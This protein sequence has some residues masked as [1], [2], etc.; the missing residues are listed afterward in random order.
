MEALAGVTPRIN[1][2]I[3]LDFNGKQQEAYLEYL[4]Q[5]YYCMRSMSEIL[6][7]YDTQST[8]GRLRP[9]QVAKV[10][11]I[12]QQCVD[13]A[14][15]IA[16]KQPAV[17]SSTLQVPSITTSP[18]ETSPPTVPVRQNRSRTSSLKRNKPFLEAEQ[19][20]DRLMRTHQVKLQ[21]LMRSQLPQ[22][23]LKSQITQLN[24]A[25]AREQH[26]NYRIAKQKYNEMVERER[27]HLEP[28][29]PAKSEAVPSRS[30]LMAVL[31]Q[32]KDSFKNTITSFARGL[33]D[34]GEHPKASRLSQEPPLDSELLKLTRGVIE[35]EPLA[36][37]IANSFQDPSHPFGKNL[38][39]FILMW[40][41]ESGEDWIS[42]SEM[43][44]S[45][46]DYIDI[47]FIMILTF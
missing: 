8:T 33:S 36:D 42:F 12:F 29:E 39:E 22:D 40:K 21:K 47:L 24:L 25:L 15:A 26:E 10:F 3:S 14:K 7:T 1:H 13:R 28:S 27:Q 16:V 6:T 34:R 20:N 35:R 4:G 9:E 18:A 11:G 32:K 23:Q 37:H 5:Y 38:I 46:Q 41:L 31:S 44:H 2:A 17:V 30:P 19:A 43:K 45:L